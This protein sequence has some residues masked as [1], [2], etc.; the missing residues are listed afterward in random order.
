MRSARLG[1]RAVANWQ[2]AQREADTLRAM[3]EWEVHMREYRQKERR[4]ALKSWVMLAI[5]TGLCVWAI[6]LIMEH[7]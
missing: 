7:L 1:E 4:A 6:W 5:G 2:D 3:R